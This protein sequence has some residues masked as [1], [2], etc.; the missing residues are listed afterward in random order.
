M[1]VCALYYS[2]VQSVH[3]LARYSLSTEEK[4]KTVSGKVRASYDVRMKSSGFT[5][6]RLLDMQSRL[7]SVC[8][9]G[10]LGCFCGEL[11]DRAEELGWL[12][13]DTYYGV[14]GEVRE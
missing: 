5:M 6:Y 11:L 4:R 14:L 10:K 1:L 9:C 13:R 3:Y 8:V 2:T 7:S 12:H